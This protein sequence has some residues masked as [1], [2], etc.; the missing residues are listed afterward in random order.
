MTFAVYPCDKWSYT[1]AISSLYMGPLPWCWPTWHFSSITHKRQT[2][3]M[4]TRTLCLQ[5]AAREPLCLYWPLP[6][7]FLSTLILSSHCILFLVSGGFCLTR[8]AVSCVLV[9]FKIVSL[10]AQQ[11][12]AIPSVNWEVFTFSQRGGQSAAAFSHFFGF[13]LWSD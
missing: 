11:W 8:Q 7:M 12:D 3:K 6:L 2:E 13:F 1:M 5:R 10:Q 4:R 9:S